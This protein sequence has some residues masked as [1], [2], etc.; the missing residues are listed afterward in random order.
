MCYDNDAAPPR[1]QPPITGTRAADVRLTSSDG[2]GFTAYEARPDDVRG[3][4][5]VIVPDVRGLHG[6]YRQ[7]AVRLAEQGHP[8][9]AIDYYGRTAPGDDRGES[10]P[11]MELGTPI[12]GLFGGADQGIPADQVTEFDAALTAAGVEHEIVTY[13]GAPHG[14]F[15]AGYAGHAAACA[16]A[17]NRVLAFLA[18]R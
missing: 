9:I 10:F 6:F 7:L 3:S 8:A 5:V 16:D 4:G 1:L 15:D 14:F 11:V 18:S 2:T 17:W 12:L 13:P